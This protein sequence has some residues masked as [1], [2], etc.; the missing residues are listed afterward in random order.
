MLSLPVHR[1]SRDST[2]REALVNPVE[3]G[4]KHL[5]SFRHC[6]GKMPYYREVLSLIE[7]HLRAQK[8][9]SLADFNKRIVLSIC[10]YLDIETETIELSTLNIESRKNEM[11]AE[12]G[13]KLSAQ[14]YLS[15]KGGK[16]YVTGEEEVYLTRGLALAY[17]DFQQLG[18]GSESGPIANYSILDS[19]CKLGS[20][21]RTLVANDEH[22]P[23]SLWMASS[24]GS[25]TNESVDIE[26]LT[27]AKV[28]QH[29]QQ[30][31]SLPHDLPLY[32][33]DLGQFLTPQH[34]KFALSLVATIGGRAIGYAVASVRDST[35]AHLHQFVVAPE[36]RRLGVGRALLTGLLDRAAAH[37]HL[38]LT[39]KV[40]RANPKAFDFYRRFGFVEI[41][42]VNRLYSE[43]AVN[44]G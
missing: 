42:R 29:Q 39:V 34:G 37:A 18:D 2:I 16:A 23:L 10:D 25:G 3:F 40:H 28:L 17:H 12:I 4:V 44:L 11:I 26:T 35:T 36:A 14:I 21:T 27:E 22:V 1:A 13:G 7:P 30:L 9:I 8:P 19:L 33:W 5:E 43:L 38:R 6:Y 15:G 24:T 20:E 41:N 31:T 32:R